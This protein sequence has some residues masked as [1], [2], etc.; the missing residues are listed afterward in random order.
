MVDLAY[1][2]T[3]YFVT[4]GPL[5][6]IPAFYVAAEG[7]DRRTTR[8]MAVRS[9]I[10]AS[11]IVLFVAAVASGTMETWRVS[12]D[13]IAIAGGIVLL[14]SAI[15]MLTAF[16]LAGPPPDALPAPA[17]FTNL[18]WMG[19]PILSPLAIPS[20]VTPIG[21]VVV[22]Y[23][24]GLAA[25]DMPLQG[26]LIG[27]LLMIMAL[28]LLAMLCARPIM[29]A[30]GLPVLQV[31][32]WVFSALQAG[33]AVEV[34]VGAAQRLGIAS[35]LVLVLASA[36]AA[37]ELDPRAFARAPVGTTIV[38]AGIGGSRGDILFDPSIGVADAEADLHIVTTGFGY[39][40]ALAGRQARVLAVVPIAW[41]NVAGEVQG[42]LQRQDLRGLAD[43]RIKFSIGVH[44]APALQAAEFAAAPKGTAIGASVTVM[45]PWGQ[46]RSGQLVNLGY[47]RWALKPEIGVTR[48]IG[49]WTVEGAVGVWLFTTN[50][51]Y[52]PGRLQKKQD[53][54]ASM[55]GHVSY[56]FPKRIWLGA[57]GTWFGGGETRVEG[58]INPDEQRNMRLGATLSIPLGK[59]QSMKV[60]YSTGASTRRGTD[61]DSFSVTWQLAR[62]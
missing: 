32:G 13:A 33:L 57:A 52:Y 11:A 42:Q 23:F 4:L 53:P 35:V 2:F 27:L 19:R 55:Q 34:L 3:L 47:N 56:A 48:P 8:M 12:T 30:L 37:Q 62:Y 24:S 38:L 41:G 9:A 45:P 22:L 44:G 1:A 5:K 16:Q 59:W 25:G 10:V 49:R 21:I 46:Y 15:K 26:R 31:I 18:A 28:N 39:T 50:D 20:I 14:M 54:V 60:V 29:R 58:V 7:A 61:F 6:T 36:A 43:P 17:T 40:F 51:A